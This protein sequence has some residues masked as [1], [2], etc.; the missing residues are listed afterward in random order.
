VPG[1]I[2][3]AEEE[4]RDTARRRF[5]AD[6]GWVLR[7]LAYGFEDRGAAGTNGFAGDSRIPE[8]AVLILLACLL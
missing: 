6:L 7:D 3:Q 8:A 4:A 2:I 1:E 5:R